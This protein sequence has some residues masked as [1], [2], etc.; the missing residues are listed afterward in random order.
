MSWVLGMTQENILQDTSFPRIGLS[1]CL[2]G[3]P[4]CFSLLPHKEPFVKAVPRAGMVQGKALGIASAPCQAPVCPA[5]TTH[6]GDLLFAE[7]LDSSFM[8]IFP[9]LLALSECHMRLLSPKDV[10]I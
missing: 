3:L 2:T 5:H 8:L 4:L 1:P 7:Y 6:R 9:R 10:V